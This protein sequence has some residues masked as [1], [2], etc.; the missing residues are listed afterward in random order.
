MANL[1]VS[2]VSTWDNSG[3]KK[4]QKSLTA[5][6]RSIKNLGKTFASVFAARSLVAFGKKAV[7]AFMADEKAAKSLELQLK[8]T[9]YAFSAPDVEYYIANLQKMYGVLDDE[10][11][12]AFQTLLTASGSIIKSQ[13]ALNTALN[14]SAAT[15]KSV[16]EVSAAMAKGFSG[17]TTALTRLGVGLNKATLASGDMNKIMNE[18]DTKFAGQATARLSTYAGKMD[19]LKVAAADASEIIGKDLLDSLSAF[20]KDDSLKGFS[21]LLT[22]LAT[23]LAALDKAV[24]GFAAKMLGIKK[25]GSNFTYSLGANAGVELAKKKEADLLKKTNA[26][27]AAELVLLDKKTSIDKLKE[28]FD[29]E[30]IGLNAALNQATDEETKLRL[31]AQLAILDNDEVMAKKLLAEMDAAEA[32]KA[33]KEE[34]DKLAKAMADAAKRMGDAAEEAYKRLAVYNPVAAYGATNSSDIATALLALDAAKKKLSGLQSGGA[35]DTSNSIINGLV[36]PNY[37]P[38]GATTNYDPLSSLMANTA[39]I[40]ATGA[41]NPLSGLRPTQADINVYIDASNMVDP[42]NMTKV[43]QEAFLQINKN[44]YSTTPAGQGF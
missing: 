29:L 44:G 9:G 38:P 32:L 2:A 41:F 19:Q 17:Q 30:R 11:R 35:V 6:D 34:T 10:L 8:N 23:K 12:P 24:F 16:E 39:D 21:D 1:V 43:V 27:R 4:G 3:L 28:K 40:A 37:N 20:S 22:G 7:N 36:N 31:R 13:K 25:Q 33:L 26:G 14:V 5:F 15:G 18:L 42:A